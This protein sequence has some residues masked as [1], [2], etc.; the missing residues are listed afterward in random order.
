MDGVLSP[1]F[2]PP[3]VI[4]VTS[5]RQK[6]AVG[7]EAVVAGEVAVGRDAAVER[8]VAIGP[9]AAV[10]RETVVERK[11][12]VRTEA[13]IRPWLTERPEVRPVRLAP[14]AVR[15]AEIARTRL[16][17]YLPSMAIAVVAPVG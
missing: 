17:S 16:R 15:R 5:G 3:V 10:G 7:R 1:W 14:V 6:A 8:K 4:F 12:A 11:V 9:G 13:A 2:G